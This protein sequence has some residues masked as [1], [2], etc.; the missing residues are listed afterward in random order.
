MEPVG[1]QCLGSLAHRL[2]CWEALR[3]EL[4]RSFQALR[5]RAPELGTEVLVLGLLGQLQPFSWRSDISVCL[6]I[7]PSSFLGRLETT[8]SW[9]ILRSVMRWSLATSSTTTS[10]NNIDNIDNID[11]MSV[12]FAPPVEPQ[13]PQTGTSGTSTIHTNQE[14]KPG[15]SG[16]SFIINDQEHQRVSEN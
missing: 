10:V 15:S 11:W 4:V 6:R 2:S 14:P 7:A 8:L 5:D 9:V 12:I 3:T 16:T 13:Q 1:R